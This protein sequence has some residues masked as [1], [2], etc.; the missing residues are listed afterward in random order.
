MYDL[1]DRILGG[2]IGAGAGDA[3][4]AATE[5]RTTEQI[6]EYFGHQVTDF[7][8]PPMDT[9]G[10]G[11]VPGQLTDDFSSAYFVAK[12]ILEHEGEVSEKIIQQALIDWSEHPVFFDRFAGPTTRLAIRR[13]KGEKI[14]RSGG[15]E[16]VTRQ[17]TNG[18]A[19]KISPIGL[20]N[21]GDVD[22]AIQEAVTVTMVTHD[23]Y[24]ALSGAC[25]VA[26][27]VSEAASEGA[28]VYRVLQAGLYGAREGERIGREVARDVAGPSV[29][30]RM[31]MA[32]D[33]GLG[34]GTPWEKMIELGHRIGAGLHVSEAIP[35]AFGFF[36]ANEGDA[37]GSIVGAVN[38]GYDT[39]TI[40]TMSGALAG[41]LKGAKAY[42]EHFLP[43]LEKANDLNIQ[44][45][46]EGIRKVVEE[47]WAKREG[48]A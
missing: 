8:T 22:R 42:P 33:I 2:L 47:R 45:L 44:E 31:E 26:A 32:I 10:A 48:R 16:L 20:F 7:E 14:E 21:V 25:A 29:V 40:A 9:F 23:N 38:V 15:V 43:T 4:G 28:D 3:M 1:Y 5:A 18:A 24:L 37:L 6:L 30:K 19:M 11:N 27:A 41:A 46:A 36:A 13:Y 39:D 17:A 34:S 12:H 35:C